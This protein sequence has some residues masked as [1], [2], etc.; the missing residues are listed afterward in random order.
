MVDAPLVGVV[1]RR[2]AAGAAPLGF[3]RQAGIDAAGRTGRAGVANKSEICCIAAGCP[4][5]V[6]GGTHGC[7]CPGALRHARGGK[8]AAAGVPGDAVDMELVTAGGQIG[9]G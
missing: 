3:G 6:P 2:P 8:A 7:G 4:R 1:V 9:F 5:L